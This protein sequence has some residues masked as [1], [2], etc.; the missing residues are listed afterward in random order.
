MPKMNVNLYII[1]DYKNEPPS[2]PKKQTQSKPIK[3]CPERSRMGQFLQTPKCTK[4]RLPKNPAKP[5]C[6][7]LQV[8]YILHSHIMAKR[9][10]RV[11]WPDYQGLY[12]FG[13]FMIMGLGG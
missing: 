9:T 5:F 4:N 2:G 6:I 3:P 10:M 13:T 7:L 8:S 12:R 1:E 11:S